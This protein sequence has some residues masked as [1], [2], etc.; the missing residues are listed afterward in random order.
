MH[1]KV[2]SLIFSTFMDF[3]TFLHFTLSRLA[4]VNNRCTA[5]AALTN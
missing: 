1:P 4:I 2:A 5:Y 3:F